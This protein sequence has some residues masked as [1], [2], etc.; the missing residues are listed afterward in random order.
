MFEPYGKEGLYIAGPECFYGRGYELWWAQ[1]KLAEYHGV[2][3]V[4]P[5]STELK[6]DA[7]DPKLN[8]KEIFDD[9]IVQ[10][11]RT[12]SII[13]DLEFF[14]GCEPDG[15]TVFELGW[16]WAK[17]GRLYG[18]SRDLRP[19]SVK[20]QNARLED[21]VLLDQNGWRHPYGDLPF[22]P[23]LVGSTRLVEGDFADALKVYLMDLDEERKGN[24]MNRALSMRSIII[25]GA[26]PVVYLSGPE[27]YSPDAL[28]FYKDAKELCGKL[29]YSAVCPLDEVEEMPAPDTE[30]PYT[31]A[32]WR[33]RKSMALLAA[34]DIVVANLADFHGW[35]PNNDV[36]FECGV[37]YGL[38]KRCVGYMPDTSIMR[39]RIPHYG[40]EKG[41]LDW[42][43]N[44][45]ENF[46]HPINLMFACSMPIFEGPLE[47]VLQENL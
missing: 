45:V 2:P 35:E 14:R 34:S 44:A 3:V 46:D 29:G 10:V 18:Y 37:A 27:R 23:S 31:L 5:T 22:C 25:A 17:K 30:D 12:T 43:G 4:L 21:G 9:L 7:T 1:R 32:A 6:L 15:G 19:M 47:K 33:F 8:A 11:A 41:N 20:N 26:G 28:R 36:S 40:E 16:V 24:S 13:A 38:G 39:R 42:C